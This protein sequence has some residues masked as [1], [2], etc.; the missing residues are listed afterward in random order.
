MSFTS[1][2]RMLA[3]TLA[4][5]WSA[6]ASADIGLS[7]KCTTADPAFKGSEVLLQVTPGG[8]FMATAVDVQITRQTSPDWHAEWIGISAGSEFQIA[9][10]LRR[11]S[12]G[13]ATLVGNLVLESID[14]GTVKM[15]VTLTDSDEAGMFSIEAERAIEFVCK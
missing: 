14:A 8:L 2:L 10:P 5:G 3:L 4:L 11:S 12:D 13:G 1:K 6:A 7:G 15:T 9:T